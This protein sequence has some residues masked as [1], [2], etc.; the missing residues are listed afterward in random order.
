M[1]QNPLITVIIPSYKSPDLFATLRSLTEQD[2]PHIQPVLVDDGTP[3]FRVEEAEGFFRR[4]DRGNLEQ[5][6]VIQNPENRGTVYTMNRALEESRGEIIFNLAGDDCFYDGRVLSDWVEAFRKTGAQVMT[7]RRELWNADLTQR[8]G[9]EPQKKQI[10]SLQTKSPEDLFEELARV[11]YV[12]GSCTARTAESFRKYGLYDEGYR[13]IEDHPTVLKLLRLGEPIV[14]FDRTV[15]K[16]RTGGSSSA[17]NY[18]EAYARDVDRILQQEVLPHT[19]HPGAMKR[20]FRRWKREQRILRKRAAL[21][22]RFGQGKAAKLCIGAWYY[23]HHPI[24]VLCKL[25]KK[26]FGTGGK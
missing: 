7:G 17:A 4:N 24:N 12:F 3:S 1:C 11:N 21:Y 22:R 13:L 20:A 19:K 18:N 16:C 14:F 5:I 2:Y 25:P 9:L 6:R 26:L 10:L 23:L 15:V 8:L